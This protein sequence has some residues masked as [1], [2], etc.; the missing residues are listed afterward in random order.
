MQLGLF[1]SNAAPRIARLTDKAT[2]HE[3]AADTR[4]K[5]RGLQLAF[6]EAVA[7]MAEPAT[8]A[9]IAEAAYARDP[10]SSRES[11]RKRA[12]ECVRAGFIAE[13]G[14]RQCRISGKNC[15]L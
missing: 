10:S 13:C 7:S 8:A 11:Y 4:P 6:V 12:L 9:E 14:K 5:L 2:S 15:T 3:A 1:E